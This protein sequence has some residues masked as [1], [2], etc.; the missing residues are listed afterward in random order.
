MGFMSCDC[1]E[2]E[3]RKERPSRV[4]VAVRHDGQE[5]VRVYLRT[6]QGRKSRTTLVA[7]HCPFCGLPYDAPQVEATDPLLDAAEAFLSQLK[8]RGGNPRAIADLRS[9]IDGYKSAEPLSC[10]ECGGTGKIT[11]IDGVHD[12][13]SCGTRQGEEQR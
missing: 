4:S 7:S 1:I 5:R 13:T 11:M 12:C 10:A 9:S 8:E 3:N 2:R 6:P